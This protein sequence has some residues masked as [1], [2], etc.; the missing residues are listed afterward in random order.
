MNGP[1]IIDFFE[2]QVLI[3]A[4]RNPGTILRSSVLLKAVDSWFDKFNANEKAQIYKY[5][6]RVVDHTRLTDEDKLLL[7]RYNPDNQY[8][9]SVCYN[10]E[11]S[12]IQAFKYADKYYTASRQFIAPEYIVSAGKLDGHK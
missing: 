5:Y 1:I 7:A 4:C 6:S 11:N 3:E 9:V 12:V 2:V 10:G 8:A